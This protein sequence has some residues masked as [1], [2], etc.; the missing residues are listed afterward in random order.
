VI[1]ERRNSMITGTC[2]RSVAGLPNRAYPRGLLQGD[3][4]ERPRNP[5]ADR[6]CRRPATEAT[7]TI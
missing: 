3:G 1:T 4:H 5:S 7:I 2:A 6:P